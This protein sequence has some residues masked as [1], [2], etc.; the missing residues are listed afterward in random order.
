MTLSDKMAYRQYIGSR[1]V[2]IFGRKGEDSYEWD[3]SA[4]YEP[5]TVVM[6]QGNSFTSVQYVPTGI[7]INNRKYW[8]ET[9]NWNAQIESYRQT[10]LSFDGRITANTEASTANAEA[11]TAEVTRA[12]NAETANREA[13][14]AETTRA[15]AAETANREAITAETTRA[16][17]A[18]TANSNAIT[19]AAGTR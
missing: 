15:S 9:G 13:I 14:T 1:Y 8:A 4:P 10:V 2:P 17:A 16:S 11:I 7:D 6:H 18:E 12:T 5:L 3:N 19:A